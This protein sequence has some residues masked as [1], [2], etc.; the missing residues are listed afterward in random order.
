MSAGHIKNRQ[1]ALLLREGS[2][3]SMPAD[4]VAV[5][6]KNRPCFGGNEPFMLLE[7]TVNT[8]PGIGVPAIAVGDA[9]EAVKNPAV[10]RR[11]HLGIILQAVRDQAIA[12]RREYVVKN[13]ICS[14]ATLRSG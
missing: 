6:A 14:N 13:F 12:V 9:I 3:L 7:G 4:D 10:M 1:F 2:I 5:A 11:M 8:M